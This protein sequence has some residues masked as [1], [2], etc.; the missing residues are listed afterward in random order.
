MEIENGA[1]FPYFSY[2]SLALFIKTFGL[3]DKHKIVKKKNSTSDLQ[4]PKCQI[5]SHIHLYI[6][7]TY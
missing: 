6:M 4:D 1:C 2:L 5:L 7:S 3:Y